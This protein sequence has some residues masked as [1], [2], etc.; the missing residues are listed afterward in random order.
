MEQRAALSVAHTV[1]FR[2]QKVQDC[3]LLMLHRGLLP[4]LA[5][6][7]GVMLDE[8]DNQPKRRVSQAILI[9]ELDI[10]E[11]RFVFF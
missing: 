8:I 1:P 2:P 6:E 10:V 4:K 3:Q 7:D 11:P 9:L 5:L